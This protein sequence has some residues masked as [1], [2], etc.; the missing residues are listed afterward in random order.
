MKQLQKWKSQGI[1]TDGSRE[2]AL[3]ASVTPSLQKQTVQ[4]L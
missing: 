4:K 2:L 1:P 3:A